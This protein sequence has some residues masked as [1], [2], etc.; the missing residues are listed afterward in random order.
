[1]VQHPLPPILSQLRHPWPL[2]MLLVDTHGKGL[3]KRWYNAYCP[4]QLVEEGHTAK[5]HRQQ[6][7]CQWRL[8]VDHSSCPDSHF[9]V[10]VSQK[11]YTATSSHLAHHIFNRHQTETLCVPFPNLFC[12]AFLF[13]I[14]ET[15]ALLSMLYFI[16]FQLLFL[17]LLSRYLR[18][19]HKC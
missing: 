15:L 1:M 12:Q 7:H 8:F 16:V 14:K 2:L 6:G 5:W 9:L 11:G 3:F 17:M 4:R 19:K 13:V 18:Y 10:T